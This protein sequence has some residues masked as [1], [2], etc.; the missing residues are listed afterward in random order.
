MKKLKSNT[1]LLS[2]KNKQV[3]KKNYFTKYHAAE[4]T[5]DFKKKKGR[6]IVLD[7]AWDSKK[8]IIEKAFNTGEIII[9][10]DLLEEKF[11][12]VAPQKLVEL[13]TKISLIKKN[14]LGAQFKRV[15][16]QPMKPSEIKKYK[17]ALAVYSLQYWTIYGA[18]DRMSEEV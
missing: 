16:R 4:K 6:I 17:W 10:P 14:L 1:H 15:N 18:L 13:K 11:Y 12:E 3:K 9:K 7:P 5:V 2:K 8:R